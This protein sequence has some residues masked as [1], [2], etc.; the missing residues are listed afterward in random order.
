[1]GNAYRITLLLLNSFIAHPDRAYV[2]AW[3]L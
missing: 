3:A 2:I 1:M